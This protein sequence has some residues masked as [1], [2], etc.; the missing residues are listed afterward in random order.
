MLQIEDLVGIG[1]V[2][3]H[4][5]EAGAFALTKRAYS[6]AYEV[7]LEAGAAG[8]TRYGHK[9]AANKALLRDIAADPDF[10]RVTKELKKFTVHESG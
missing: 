10:A 8:G 6:V 2:L 7:T 5:G 4:L 3:K 1:A 9:V